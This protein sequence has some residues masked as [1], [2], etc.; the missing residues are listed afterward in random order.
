MVFKQLH[1]LVV[2]LIPPGIL[3][4]SAINVSHINGEQ[5]IRVQG[6]IAL[7]PVQFLRWRR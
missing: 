5:L 4:L 6:F 7:C 1:Q 3:A 2:G